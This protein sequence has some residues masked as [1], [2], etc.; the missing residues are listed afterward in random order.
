MP[1]ECVC[2]YDSRFVLNLMIILLHSLVGC[3][4][5]RIIFFFKGLILGIHFKRS[6]IT[7]IICEVIRGS[8][9]NI[10]FELFG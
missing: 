1:W 3:H 6:W 9:M 2:A 8:P 5:R 7:C 10:V 4:G